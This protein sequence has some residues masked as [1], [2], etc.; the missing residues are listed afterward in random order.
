MEPIR[1]SLDNGLNVILQP[2]PTAPVVAC[3]VWVNVG[4]ADETPEEAGLAHVHEHMLFKGT[5]RRGVGVVAREVEASGGYINAFTSFDHTCYYLVMSSRQFETG[6]DLLSDVI[7]NSSFDAEE[8]GREL[9][10]IQEEIKRGNDSPQRVASQMLFDTAFTT[11][12]YKLPVIGTKESVD[13]FTRDHVVNF[14]NK[15][16]R[17]DNST[18]VLV[19][20]FEEE[21]ARDFVNKYFGDWTAPKYTPVVRP[22][23]PQQREFRGAVESKEIAANHLRCAFHVPNVQHED[24]PAIDVL[25][26]AMGYGDASHLHQAVQR[27]TEMTTGV[28]AMA[29]T[30][31]DDGILLV[32]ADYQIGDKTPNHA[33]VASKVLEEVF[34]FRHMRITDEDLTRVRTLIESQEIYSQQSAEGL[35]MKMGRNQMVTGDP[36]FDERY[37]AALREVT[38]NDVVEAARKYLTPTN[39]TIALLRSESSDEVT[40]DELQKLAEGAFETIETQAVDANITLDDRGFYETQIPGGPRLVVQEDHSVETFALRAMT[41]GGLRYETPEINGITP[42]LSEMVVAGT[43]S[44]DA[45]DIARQTESMASGLSGIAGRNSFGFSMTGISRFFD[46]CFDIY[47]DCAMNMNLPEE[48]FERT[49]RLQLQAITSREDQLGAVNFQRFQEA[50][51]GDYP[52]GMP[53]LGTHESVNALTPERARDYLAK[54]VRPENMVIT[55]VGDI[56]A[57]MVAERVAELFVKDAAAAFEPK[58]PAVPELGDARLVMGNLEKEQAFVTVGFGA[59]PLGHSARH[60]LEVVNS[61]LSGMA[62]RLFSELRE[63]QSLA[64]SVFASSLL[65]IDAS[66]FTINIGTSPEKVEQALRGMFLEVA[67]LKEDG[68]TDEELRDAKA[69]L[70]GNH[71]IGLQ[72]NSSRAMSF[73]LDELYGFGYEKTLSYSDRIEAISHDDVNAFVAEFLKPEHAVVSITKP[74]AVD[75]EIDLT[76]YK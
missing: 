4:S 47:A 2:R 1:Y 60:A 57:G 16:Y 45:V 72:K 18:V 34:R 56:D 65:G 48:E 15:H 75:I 67:K 62:G 63:K 44:R 54:L 24:I 9:E 46:R 68:I 19:G 7:R 5:E 10:V 51:F 13:S 11:H 22:K 38:A 6:V 70:I 59:P 42:M 30:P 12:P 8:L 41:L 66:A 52:Y 21:T 61:V 25:S 43:P 36:D 49:R 3:N 64:Y 35:A 28:Y 40:V 32:A 31:K 53:T 73:A 33:A 69:S 74:A 37:Y 27:E 39:L 50:F 26:A 29:Y 20:D 76:E 55:A 14:F 71:D 58:I 17:P 23:E